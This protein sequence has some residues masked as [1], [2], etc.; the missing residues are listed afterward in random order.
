[1]KMRLYY[2]HD[3]MCSWC[4][5]FRPTLATLSATLPANIE[6]HKLLGGLAPDSDQPM[7]ATMREQIRAT[8]QHIQS[9]VPGTEFNFDFWQQCQPRRSTWMACR[10]VLIAADAGLADRMT[11]AIQ[12][13]Y[14]LHARNPSDEA[15]LIDLAEQLGLASQAF[16]DALN[17]PATHAR[18]AAEMQ[19]CRTL[20]LNAYPSLLLDT[21]SKHWPI[22]VDYQNAN[23]I[24]ES[25][26]SL[27][28]NDA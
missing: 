17:S 16:A 21:G 24:L 6:L 14:Y 10:A 22:A 18:L 13:A 9:S 2:A 20:D 4:W 5:A 8:W 28:G 23:A 7:P 11:H 27:V 15:V 25:I 26:D 12:Q 19:R 3:P 1:M